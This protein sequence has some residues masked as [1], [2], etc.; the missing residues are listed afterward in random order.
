[1]INSSTQSREFYNG[2]I[3]IRGGGDNKVESVGGKKLGIGLVG[4]MN[5]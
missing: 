2:I 1:M 3:I 5:G 4:E